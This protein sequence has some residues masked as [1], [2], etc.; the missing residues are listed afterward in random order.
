[1]SLK[2]GVMHKLMQGHAVVGLDSQ[3]RSGLSVIHFDDA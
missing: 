2:C 1:M 3:I